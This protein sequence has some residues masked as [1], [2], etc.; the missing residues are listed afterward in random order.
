[1]TIDDVFEKAQALDITKKILAVHT[2]SGGYSAAAC[3]G[4]NRDIGLPRDLN[5]YTGQQQNLNGDCNGC[6]QKY[7]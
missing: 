1:L 5:H 4:E 2:E 6:P 7:F 3:P